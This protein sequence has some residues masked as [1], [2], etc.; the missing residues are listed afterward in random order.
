VT[1]GARLRIVAVAFAAAGGM[2]L[3]CSAPTANMKKEA[4]ARMQ[5]GVTY[6]E[7][8]NLPAAMRELTKAKELDPDNPATDMMLGLAY[9]KRGD[10]EK[11][12][13]YLRMA[14][15]KKPDYAE[16]HNNLGNLLSLQGKSEEA[17]REYEKA[18]ENVTYPTPEY[19]YY[20]MGREYALLKDLPKA[21]AMYRRAIVLR[22]SFVEAYQE[23]AMVQSKEGKWKETARTL[24]KMVEIAPFYAP[25]WMDL[26]RLYLRLDRPGEALEAFRNA[27]ANSND[28]GLRTEAAGYIDIL[29]LERR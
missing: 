17:I 25:G 22:P 5:M 1:R 11:A 19:A 20:N 9:Q 6:L 16:A 28:P 2:L 27:M 29:E 18:V 15:R 14:I 10:L 13:E 26:G 7:Q 23:L 24:E 8:H 21:E 4:S 12:E 3:S